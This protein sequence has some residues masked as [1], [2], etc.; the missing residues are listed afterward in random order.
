MKEL[1]VEEQEL[2]VKPGHEIRTVLFS[3]CYSSIKEKTRRVSTNSSGSVQ[4]VNHIL[5]RTVGANYHKIRRKISS[6][7]NHKPCF[8]P[9]TTKCNAA[10]IKGQTNTAVKLPIGNQGFSQFSHFNSI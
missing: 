8:L 9:I 2:I 5:H 7:H 3:E 10:G 1:G 6:I 4:L